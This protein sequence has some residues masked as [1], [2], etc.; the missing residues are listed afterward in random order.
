MAGLAEAA[1]LPDVV[2]DHLGVSRS[3]VSDRFVRLDIAKPRQPATLESPAD[4][5][6]RDAALHGDVT[7]V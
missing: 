1:E 6:G 4:G 2:M 7:A 5:G 3:L